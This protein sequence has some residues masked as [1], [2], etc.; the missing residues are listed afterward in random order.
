MLNTLQFILSHPLN[1][2]HKIAALY[3]YLDW[4]IISR[5]AKEPVKVRFVNDAVLLVRPGMTGATGNIYCGLH[6]FQE[7]S[8]LLHYLR[9]GDLFFDI[10]ANVGSYT[11]LASA[12]TRAN[13][14][15]FEPVPESYKALL[16]NIRINNI[17]S[18]AEAYLIAIGETDGE[19][20]MTNNLDTTNHIILSQDSCS[21]KMITV[22]VKKISN[23]ISNKIPDLIKI[24]VEGYE[25]K[26]VNGAEA[27]FTDNGTNAVI[28][29]L[30]GSGERYGFNDNKLHQKMIKFGYQAYIYDPFKRVLNKTE[31]RN[32]GSGNA[33]YL[34]NLVSVRERVS[35]AATFH[36]IKADI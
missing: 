2:Q 9:Q 17:E 30:N 26:V 10:G 34:K 16:E 23:Y 36:V 27:I 35:T 21:E 14:K 28:M 25:T 29:E 24:D 6:E 11:V 3:R 18:L 33:L 13:T 20:Q 7:M 4:Q 5:L 19:I 32:T 8:F 22:P 1:R 31:T 12:V 15:A